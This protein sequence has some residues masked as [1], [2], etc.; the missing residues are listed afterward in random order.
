MSPHRPTRRSVFLWMLSLIIGG[1]GVYNLLLAWDH[2]RYAAHYQDLGVS[3]PPKLRAAFALIWGVVLIVL[4]IG[5]IRRHPWARR[6]IL[7][8]LSNYGAFGVLWLLI[9]AQSDFSQGRVAFQAAL[10]AILVALVGWVMMWRRIRRSFEMPV[11]DIELIEK[12]A[13]QPDPVLSVEK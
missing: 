3:Y 4:G 1:I 11:N 12:P 7:I 9:Y 5:L 10:T 2:L 13:E 8:I 6:W